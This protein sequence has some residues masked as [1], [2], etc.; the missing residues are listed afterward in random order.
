MRSSTS[1]QANCPFERKR[2]S[3]ISVRKC[4]ILHT[5]AMR[6]PNRGNLTDPL[7]ADKLHLWWVK[8][9]QNADSNSPCSPSEC[10]SCTCS[11]ARNPCSG[12][13]CLASQRIHQHQEL[14]FFFHFFFLSSFFSF[15]GNG[16]KKY[17]NQQTVFKIMDFEEWDHNYS[18]LLCCYHFDLLFAYSFN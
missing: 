7:P 18:K 2:P 8:V 9:V 1:N 14:A 15:C 5:D 16:F 4:D 6:K 13:L 11:S 3:T 12:W 17:L 10:V